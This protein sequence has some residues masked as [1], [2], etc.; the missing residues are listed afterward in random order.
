MCCR[1]SALSKFLLPVDEMNVLDWIEERIG[2]N[3]VLLLV[4][5]VLALLMVAVVLLIVGLTVGL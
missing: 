2:T 4:G 1:R 5:S 3:A